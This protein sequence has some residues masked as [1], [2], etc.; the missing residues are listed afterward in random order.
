MLISAAQSCSACDTWL[1]CCCHCFSAIIFGMA[2]TNGLC[3]IARCIK[4]SSFFSP[5]M[6]AMRYSLPEF[7]MLLAS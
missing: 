2:G 1:G 5:A 4:T 3:Q 6:L 7:G